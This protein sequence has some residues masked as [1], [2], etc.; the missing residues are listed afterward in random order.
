MSEFQ[1]FKKEL[2]K[3][4][5]FRKEYQRLAPRYRVISEI[6][7]ARLRRKMTQ[8][9]LAKKVGTK[10]SAIARLES[11]NSNPSLDFLEKIAT[12]MGGKLQIRIV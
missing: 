2:L 10:Q 7:T 6:I 1:D 12:A 4:P 11:G 3:N 5:E 8:T 9:E